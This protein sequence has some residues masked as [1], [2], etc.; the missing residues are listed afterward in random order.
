MT[1]HISVP[2][3]T[4]RTQVVSSR[5]ARLYATL[6]AVF[7]VAVSLRIHFPPD[8]WRGFTTPTTRSDSSLLSRP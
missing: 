5:R 3:D 4:S 7:G 2:P 6:W 1:K 8:G